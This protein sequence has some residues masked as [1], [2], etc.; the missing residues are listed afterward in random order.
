MKLHELYL[1]VFNNFYIYI[2]ICFIN[3]NC[4][5]N[6]LTVN[7]KYRTNYVES[8]SKYDT[9]INY[10]NKNDLNIICFNIRIINRHFIEQL[11]FLENEK[12]ISWF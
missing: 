5:L 1:M 4:N 8:F 2:F 11:V 9:C 7:V 12:L 10:K 3:S 6:N